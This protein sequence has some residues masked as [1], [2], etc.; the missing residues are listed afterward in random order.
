MNLAKYLR[1]NDIP[2]KAFAER[3]GVHI[4]TIHQL[5]APSPRRCGVELAQRIVEA[6]SG[7]VTLEDL[8]LLPRGGDPRG[9]QREENTNA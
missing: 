9:E 1:I 8:L 2:R 4:G 5:C 3:L 7:A 6:T